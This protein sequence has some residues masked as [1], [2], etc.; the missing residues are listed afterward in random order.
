MSKQKEHYCEIKNCRNVGDII[1]YGHEICWKHWEE[2]C[3]KEVNIK[4]IFNIKDK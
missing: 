1:Y 3:K 2:F 4:K